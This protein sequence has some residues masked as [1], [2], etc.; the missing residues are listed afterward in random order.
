MEFRTKIDF[1]YPFPKI[2]YQD[3]ILML[4]SCFA[5][6]MGY[7][8]SISKF[9]VETNPFGVLYNPESIA[10]A[11]ECLVSERVFTE[12]DLFQYE[13]RYHSFMHHSSFSDLTPE[14][15]LARINERLEATRKILPKVNR[16]FLTFGTASV[17][18]LSETEEVVANCHK[19]PDRRFIRRRLTVDDIVERYVALI[20]M[21]MRKMGI[22]VQIILTVSPIRHLKDGAAANSRSKAILLLAAEQLV[23]RFP[24]NVF[25][26]PAYEIMND[27]L[28]DYR[29]YDSDM[30]HL[31]PIA[32]DYIWTILGGSSFSEKTCTILQ[33]CVEIQ[34]GLLHEPFNPDSPAYHRFLEQLIAQMQRVRLLCPWIDFE[35][36]MELCHTRL[37]ASPN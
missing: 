25:Y 29:F 36:E 12:A 9:M 34:K 1:P 27:D 8:L 33:A 11:L 24:R 14:A 23:E 16:I 18:L 32:I 35:K 10:A 28:R 6:H 21:L 30:L 5:E 15:T 4:G 37:N 13:D 7:H 26:F 22:E 31:T 3:G 20:E 19:L 2:D 17:F